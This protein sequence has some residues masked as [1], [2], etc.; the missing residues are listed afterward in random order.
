MKTIRG[1]FRRKVRTENSTPQA[2]DP[3][4]RACRASYLVD[5]ADEP[6]QHPE[7]HQLALVDGELLRPHAAAQVADGA[8][9]RH[10]G[11][12]AEYVAHFRQLAGWETNKKLYK[13]L[14]VCLPTLV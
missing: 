4:A 8:A 7:Q 9:V 1:K 2:A 14:E 10:A 13:L 6:L 12:H 3:A 11:V 5:P